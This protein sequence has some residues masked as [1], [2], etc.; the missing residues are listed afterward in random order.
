MVTVAL[1]RGAPLAA[2]PLITTAADTGGDGGAVSGGAVLVADESLPLPHP[3]IVKA[4]REL[5]AK[6]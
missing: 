1:S 2:T 6:R 4:V 5:M 3:A